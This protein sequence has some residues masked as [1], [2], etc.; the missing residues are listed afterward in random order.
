MLSHIS[1]LEVSEVS[2]SCS[3]LSVLLRRSSSVLLLL[4][5]Q[6]AV[7]SLRL[8]FCSSDSRSGVC[9]AVPR[10]SF[11]FFAG[12]HFGP[13]AVETQ[14]YSLPQVINGIGPV[15]C[16]DSGSL[17][18][19][20]SF[21]FHWAAVELVKCLMIGRVGSKNKLKGKHIKGLGS[22]RLNTKRALA[23]LSMGDDILAPSF[24]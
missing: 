21:S 15:I 3:V 19:T 23:S 12:I 17:I 9:L 5:F 14:A 8:S 18:N 1:W 13:A 24:S 4:L 10:K 20:G 22:K 16:L 11:M 7:V 6:A 2:W